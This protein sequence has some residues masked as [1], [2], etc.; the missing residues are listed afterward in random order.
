MDFSSFPPLTNHTAREFDW[1]SG[2][3]YY[4]AR[5]YDLN[6]G[7]FL[8]EDPMRYRS[9]GDFYTYVSNNPIRYTDPQGACPQLDSVSRWHIQCEQ[10]AQGIQLT[11]QQKCACHCAYSPNG[12][13]GQGCVD[14]CMDCYSKSPTPY[15]ACLCLAKQLYGRTKEQSE[16]DCSSLKK[17]R[18]WWPW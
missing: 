15:D 10:S 8:T 1:E 3:Y 12:P 5:Y 4:R 14:V 9:G 18:W 11:K 16:S 2:L 17:R 6:V 13:P 7:R